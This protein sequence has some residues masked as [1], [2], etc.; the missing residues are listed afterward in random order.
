MS[1]R[2]E[3]SI[4]TVIVHFGVTKILDETQIQEIGKELFEVC[5]RASGKK[6]LVLDFDGVQLMSSAMIGKLVLVNK[7]TKEHRLRRNVIHV[8]KGVLEVFK[9]SRLDPILRVNRGD[10]DQEPM[11]S[12]VPRPKPLGDLDSRADPNDR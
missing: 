9:I 2:C 4:E 12:M 10:D 6:M 5:H 11:G 3:E 8:S 7:W 1:L